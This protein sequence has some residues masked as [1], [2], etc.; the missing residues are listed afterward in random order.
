[1]HTNHESVTR[2]THPSLSWETPDCEQISV[3][4]EASAYMG[5]R[6]EWDG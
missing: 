3:S 4:A 2:P 6:T 5:A 1:M